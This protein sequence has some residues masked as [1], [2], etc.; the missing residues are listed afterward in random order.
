MGVLGGLV[1]E[2]ARQVG[3]HWRV[4]HCPLGKVP[5]FGRTTATQ[6][7][8]SL[9]HAATLWLPPHPALSCSPRD[10]TV[11]EKRDSEAKE[12]L[13]V[14]PAAACI[15]HRL[16]TLPCWCELGEIRVE[17]CGTAVLFRRRARAHS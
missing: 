17:L 12:A 13:K 4:F 5:V 3:Q 11:Y 9:A 14:S 6:P 8:S 16:T 1:K 15:Q 2:A 10:P 7:L